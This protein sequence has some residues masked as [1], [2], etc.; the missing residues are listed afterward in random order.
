MSAAHEEIVET[1]AV[2]IRDRER[3]PGEPALTVEAKRHDRRADQCTRVHSP[4]M[5]RA[6]S[7]QPSDTSAMATTGSTMVYP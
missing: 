7:P 2:H 5:I 1:I 6:R 3:H 4:S